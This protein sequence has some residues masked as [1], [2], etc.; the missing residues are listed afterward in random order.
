V[1]VLMHS[2]NQVLF[3]AVPVGTYI[4]GKFRRIMSTST[5]ATLMLGARCLGK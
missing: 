3:K 2:G 1:N 5:T 4:P